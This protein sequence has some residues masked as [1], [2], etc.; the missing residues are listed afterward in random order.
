MGQLKKRVFVFLSTAALIVVLGVGGVDSSVNAEG[1]AD[2]EGLIKSLAETD[3]PCSVA[4]LLSKTAD[5]RAV[6]PLVELIKRSKDRKVQM[7]VAQSLV[8]LDSKKSTAL[9][10]PELDNPDSLIASRAAFALGII[11]DDAAVEPLL[12]AFFEDRISRSAAEALGMIKA[13]RSLD[14][15][16]GA[17]NNQSESIRGHAVWALGDFADR[18]ACNGLL[19]LFMAEWSAPGASANQFWS[20]EVIDELQCSFD[21]SHTE[22][23]KLDDTCCD[24]AQ[25]MLEI[26]VPL[27]EK[28]TDSRGWEWETL[29]KNN[30]DLANIFLPALNASLGDHEAR[31]QVFVLYS[32]LEWGKAAVSLRSVPENEPVPVRRGKEHEVKRIETGL[33]LVCPTLKVPDYT[34]N[35]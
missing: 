11:K 32:I 18:R 1:T 4:E 5:H 7:C 10:I 13:P 16:I 25:Q 21:T 6:S 34:L 24:K 31:N 33:R 19:D 15:L 12:E 27:I 3:D 2:V 28:N 14:P 23:Y 9:L 20:M 17:L 8:A 35:K 26:L 30:A 22:K 29:I